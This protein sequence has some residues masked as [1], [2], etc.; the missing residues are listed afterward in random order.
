MNIC[1]ELPFLDN[2]PRLASPRDVRWDKRS[3]SP[4]RESSGSL[5]SRGILGK[6]H[7]PASSP[8]SGLWTNKYCNPFSDLRDMTAVI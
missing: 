4:E 1:S 8:V 6:S 5:S 7:K 2:L 3:D